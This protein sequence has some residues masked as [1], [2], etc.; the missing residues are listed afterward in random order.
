M[1]KTRDKGLRE[2]TLE[3][4][5]K[6]YRLQPLLSGEWWR[7]KACSKMMPRELKG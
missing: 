2:M 6:V 3:V 5:G 4:D 7:I 1:G